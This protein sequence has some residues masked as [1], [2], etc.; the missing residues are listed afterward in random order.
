MAIRGSISILVFGA[1]SQNIAGIAIAV[2]IIWI[3]NT[4]LPMLVGSVVHKTYQPV[5]NIN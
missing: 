4:I 5:V 1:F 3:V 2:V